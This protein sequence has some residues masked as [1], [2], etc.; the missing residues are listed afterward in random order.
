MVVD[1]LPVKYLVL[2]GNWENRRLHK[3]SSLNLPQQPY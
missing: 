2:T 3:I 1:K